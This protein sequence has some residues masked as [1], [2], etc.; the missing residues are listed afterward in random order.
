M[1]LTNSII[2][3][4][5]LLLAVSCNWNEVIDDTKPMPPEISLDNSSAVYTVMTGETLTVSPKYKYVQGATYAWTID[6]R[7]ISSEPVLLYTDDVAHSVYIK[8]TVKT[9]VGSAS[10]EI[11]VDTLCSRAPARFSL[12]PSRRSRHKWPQTMK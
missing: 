12:K 1:R 5:T 8:I 6:G 9:D 11:R 7:L 2:M 10:D 3:A 4:L